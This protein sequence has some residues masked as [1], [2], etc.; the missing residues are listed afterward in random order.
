MLSTI[1]GTQ[2]SIEKRLKPFWQPSYRLWRS[3]KTA[4]QMKALAAAFN[5]MYGD[6]SKAC[7]QA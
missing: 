5:K 3:E 7:G 2:Q 1:G 6:F 4:V